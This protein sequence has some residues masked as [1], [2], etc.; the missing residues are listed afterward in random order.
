[1]ASMFLRI[2]LLLTIFF[3]ASSSNLLSK[4]TFSKYKL[5]YMQ[6]TGKVLRKIINDKS[7]YIIDTREIATVAL[8]YIPNTLIV[9]SSMISWLYTV[10]PEMAKVVIITDEQNRDTTI[11]AFIS[12]QKYEIYGYCIY[13]KIIKTSSF[14]IQTIQYDPNTYDS[15][16]TIVDN[17]E[18]I[19]DIRE[20]KEYRE[21]GVIKQ[22]KLIPLSTFQDDY[23]NIPKEGNVY[24]FCKSGAR[25]V[26]GMSFAK[27]AGYSN[28]FIIMK[29]GMN[30]AIEEKY[31]LVPY[32][33]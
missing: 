14:N 22:A 1:M 11:D 8:G 26:V 15:I 24:V 17:N 29:G 2:F 32:E 30:K 7:F 19:I 10:I 16:K 20:I 33:G 5:G 18:N 3:N 4:S 9:P 6:I 13:D 12:L 31:P 28:K 25:A 27:R 21:T 23:I